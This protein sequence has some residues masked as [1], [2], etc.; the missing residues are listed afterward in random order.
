DA[1]VPQ[2]HRRQERGAL[3]RRGPGKS[4]AARCR[5][6]R[7][8]QKRAPAQSCLARVSHVALHRCPGQGRSSASLRWVNRLCTMTVLASVLE[9]NKTFLGVRRFTAAFRNQTKAAESP[10]LDCG[11][12]PPLL[13]TKRK[14][15]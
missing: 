11:V 14:R 8:L 12:F 15:R 6:G 4:E 13:E 10:R 1:L 3:R 9:P 7:L 2:L 5:E